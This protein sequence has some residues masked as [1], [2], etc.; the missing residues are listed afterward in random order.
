MKGNPKYK[1]GDSVQ[2][3][4]ENEGMFHGKVYIID[5]YGTFEDPS[6]V[7]YDIMVE[8]WGPKKEECL[9]KHIPEKIVL[10]YNEI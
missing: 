7:S 10:T 2:F 6:D 4:L 3:M 1:I 9:F 5:P 8:D